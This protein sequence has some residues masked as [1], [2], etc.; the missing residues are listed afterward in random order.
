MKYHSQVTSLLSDQKTSQLYSVYDIISW[1]EENKEGAS[2][3]SKVKVNYTASANMNF[4][5]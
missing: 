3:P 2:R 4:P 5:N 1:D